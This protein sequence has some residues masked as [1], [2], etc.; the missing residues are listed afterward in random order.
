VA[1]GLL[2]KAIPIS[3]IKTS[4][5]PTPAARPSYSVLDCSQTETDFGLQQFG[6]RVQL[7]QVLQLLRH[8]L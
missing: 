3:P 5:Y 8:P 4:D 7:D 1:A 6:W 2:K